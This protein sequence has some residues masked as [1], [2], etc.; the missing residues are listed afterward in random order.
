MLGLL[1]AR[2]G[3]ETLVLEKHGDFLRDFR[4]DTVHPSTLDV[5]HEL[6]LLQEF[7]QLPHQQVHELRGRIG[8][9]EFTL[10]DFSRTPTQCHFIALM[11]QWHFLNFLA[12]RGARLPK[13][14]LLMNARVTGLAQDGGG[15]RGVEAQTEQGPLHV[16]AELVIGADGRHSTVRAAAGLPVEDLGSPIDVLW[17][18]LPRHASDPGQTGG[19]FNTGRIVVTLNRGDFWQCAFVIRKGQLDTL[20]AR[21]LEAFRAEVGRIVP[22]FGDRVGELCS[23]DEIKLLTVTVDRLRKWWRPGLLCIGDAA[24]AMSPVGGVGINL[25]IQDA[26]AAANILAPA[27]LEGR[28]E[29]AHLEAVQRRRSF[30]TWVTQ[31]MQVF[32]QN[33]VIN[34]VLGVDR[35]LTV[36]W[37]LQLLNRWPRLR[38][39]PAR[40]IGVGVRPEHVR[41]PVV[42]T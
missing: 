26:V 3:I 42:A 10:A 31:A 29:A 38:R 8:D 14:Q 30:P 24:H 11:P 12:E 18:R 36:P 32:L 2:A 13:F 22:L 1:L 7:L 19:Y 4:G 28:L 27:L 16:T 6:G 34:R 25:A 23:W 9:T 39:I 37:P 17:F 41:T 5:M 33:R 21:G 35:A 40:L 20:R 15:I